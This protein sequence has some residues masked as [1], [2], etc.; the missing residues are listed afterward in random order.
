[1]EKIRH[2]NI[3]TTRNPIPDAS[4]IGSVYIS[5]MILKRYPDAHQTRLLLPAHHLHG[6]QRPDEYS[7]ASRR[8]VTSALKDRGIDFLIDHP[9]IVCAIPSEQGIVT[10][11]LQGHHRGRY[12]G[13]FNIHEIP[14]IVL[15]PEQAVGI[16]NQENNK[17]LEVESFVER[18]RRDMADAIASFRQIGCLRM[19]K[20]INDAYTISDLIKIFKP[21]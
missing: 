15:D 12:A 6:T 11:V 20:I 14:S 21:F 8:G 4:N 18:L 9:I 17:P 3:M 1:M 13:I 2:C 5:D 10:A 16:I 19:P 7:P